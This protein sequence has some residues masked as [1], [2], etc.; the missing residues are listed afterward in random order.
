[1]DPL[2]FGGKK[3]KIEIELLDFGGK[4]F[5]LGFHHR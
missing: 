1:M 4:S 5:V 3:F 2:D